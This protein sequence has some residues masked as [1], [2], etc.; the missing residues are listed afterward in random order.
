MRSFAD[1][2]S[3][4]R[5]GLSLPDV[6][7]QVSASEDMTTP[8]VLKAGLS[9]RLKIMRETAEDALAGKWHPQLVSDDKNK[10]PAYNSQPLSGA[11]IWRASEISCAISTSNAS[12]GRIVAAPTAGSCGIL[13]GLLFAWQRVRAGSDEKLLEGLIVAAGIGEIIASRATLAGASGG[14]Q[15][16]CGAAVAMAAAALCQMEGGTPEQCGNAAALSFKSL[17]GLVCDPVCGLV[18]VPCIKRN[19]TLVSISAITADMSLAGIKSFIPLDE[20]IDAMKDVGKAL[21]ETLRE[22]GRGGCART[23]TGKEVKRRLRT[24]HS[25]KVDVNETQETDGVHSGIS[26]KDGNMM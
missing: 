16:E 3:K 26:A 1:L 17:L 11:L 12:M 4:T 7:L 21:P 5:S 15:A 8:E 14:C 23:L 24:L 22:T 13:P 20:L 19:A 6:M 10:Y 18:E 2:L 9:K 25:G